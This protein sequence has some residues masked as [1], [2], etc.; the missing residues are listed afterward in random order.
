MAITYSNQV[1]QAM[2]YRPFSEGEVV[3]AHFLSARVYQLQGISLP[4]DYLETIQV[5]IADNLYLVAIGNSVNSLSRLLF[6]DDF[7]QDEVLWEK[8]N[9]CTPPYALIKCGPTGEY[10]ASHGWI[11]TDDDGITTFARFLEAKARLQY[12]EDVALP[13]LT[14][15]LL[16]SFTASSQYFQLKEVTHEVIGVTAN[17]VLVRDRHFERK[18]FGYLVASLSIDELQTTLNSFKKLANKIN[19]RVSRFIHLAQQ[20]EDPLKRFLYFFLAIEIETHSVY[21]SIEHSKHLAKLIN[22]QSHIKIAS[23]NLFESH[24]EKITNLKDR[25]IWCAMCVWTH[26]NDSDIDS[27]KRL[28]KIRDEIAHGSISV[29]PGDSVVNAEKLAVKLFV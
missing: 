4:D 16:C 23:T 19:P 15:S 27:F 6:N 24:R 9:S 2:G 5:K 26:L 12:L 7:T 29:P 22:V 8:E 14:S 17:N 21:T 10:S 28:K 1:M 25:F 20:E 11:K 13:S 18:I 3:S